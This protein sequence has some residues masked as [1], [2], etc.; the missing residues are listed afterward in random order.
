MSVLSAVPSLYGGCV[1]SSA[2]I[3]W[4]CYKQCKGT[5]NVCMNDALFKF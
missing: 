2:H 3:L 4:L 5:F 1:R